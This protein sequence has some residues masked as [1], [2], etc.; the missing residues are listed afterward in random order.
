[1]REMA[2][3]ERLTILSLALLSV[4]L[5]AICYFHYRFDSDEPQHLHVAW[6]WTA[7]LLQYRDLFDNHAPLF[8]MLTAPM[9]AAVGER[10]DVLLYMRAPMLLLFAVVL[11]ST[12]IIA[13]R[14]Y[15]TPVAVWSIVLL[16]LF[17]P[18][19][20]KSLE[21][22]ND[23]LWNAFWMLAIVVLTGGTLTR[24]RLLA[25]G[26][27]LGCALATSLK[28]VLLL[29]MLAAA[30]PVTYAMCFRQRDW[31]RSIRLLIPVLA[32]FVVVPAAVA[33]YFY[34]RGG[35]SSLVYCLIDFNAL[36]DSTQ[37]PAT[38]WTSRMIFPPALFI[39]LR[40]AWRRRIDTG[41][42]AERWRFF[43]GFGMTFYAIALAT[44][45]ILIS[46]RDLMPMFPLAAIFS[47]AAI[48]RRRIQRVSIY[49]L[50][51]VVF[52]GLIAYYTQ[53]FENRTDEYITMI[54][55][56]LRLT[57]PGEPV[58]DYKGEMVF[59]RRP[60]YHILEY[61]TRRAMRRGLIADTIPEDMVRARCFVAQA[62]GEFWPPAGRAFLRENFLD[63]GRLRAAGQWLDVH[64]S[65]SIAVPGEYAIVGQQK[66]ARGMLD[67]S[68]YRGARMLQAGPHHFVW[69]GPPQ[70]GACM[71][72][73]A[74]ARGFSP[75]H[76]QDRDF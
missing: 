45:W 71:W 54:N 27:L 13:K 55:Q 48:E 31:G 10:S 25:V 7:G 43:F 29:A 39:A 2:S 44:F 61:I 63:M 19:F 65:F 47:V 6:G 41:S 15:S 21:Y 34:V 14:L 37:L 4:V 69:E 68:P 50:T 8:H 20:L 42:T 16:S 66:E 70:R 62:D 67:G 64:G 32:G 1:M 49:A 3:R 28:T 35:W 51:A 53:R 17:P 24:F 30:A 11:S 40:L 74:F 56:L 73:P 60:F 9:L 59:R 5:R 72:A 58:M 23:N 12:W 52:T 36:L 57:R 26:F 46:P 75:F 18:F 38:L 33:A 76:L 22:R